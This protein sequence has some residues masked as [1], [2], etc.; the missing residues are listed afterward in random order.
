[1]TESK[2]YAFTP[3]RQQFEQ[4]K[5]PRVVNLQRSNTAF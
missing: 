1:L 3:D 2:E 4:S 5:A